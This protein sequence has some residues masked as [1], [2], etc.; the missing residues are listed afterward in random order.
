LHEKHFKDTGEE[1]F[2]ADEAV[3]E[4]VLGGREGGRERERNDVSW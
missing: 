4:V 2:V 1:T 3:V